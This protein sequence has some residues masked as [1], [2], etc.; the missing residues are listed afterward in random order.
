M[1]LYRRLQNPAVMQAL[2]HPLRAKMLWVL[3]GQEASPKELAVHFGVPLANIAYHIQ[4][5]R[6][7]RLIRLVKKTPRRG[8]VEHHY[9]ADHAAEIRDDAWDQAPGLIKDWI[10]AAG[11]EEVGGYVT[12]SAEMGG[13]DRSDA[14]LSRTRLVLDEE[15]WKVL[16][17]RLEDLA[18]LLDELQ[19]ES[20][21]RLKQADHSGEIHAGLVMMLFESMPGVPNADDAELDQPAAGKSDRH[22]GGVFSQ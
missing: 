15:A 1:K 3:Q 10:V 5:L 4:V 14:H 6:K 21:K 19:K 11:L 17:A 7:L 8:A 2:A 20:G 13:F 16:A 12:R 9:R 22:T 18:D